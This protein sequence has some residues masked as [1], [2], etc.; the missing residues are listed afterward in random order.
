LLTYDEAE[1]N[2]YQYVVIEVDESLPVSRDTLVA[3]L[4]AENVLARK[5]F[6][7]GCHNMKPYREL[8]P[9]AGLVLPNTQRV[10]ARVI[11]LPTGTALPPGAARTIVAI[12]QCVAEHVAKT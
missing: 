9:H 6:W 11:V 10:A 8:F 1:H 12:M 3:A 5:Y 4:N 2:N 7:P